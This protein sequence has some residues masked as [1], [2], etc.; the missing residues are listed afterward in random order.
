MRENSPGSLVKGTILERTDK[1]IKM[2]VHTI[3]G[4]APEDDGSSVITWFPLSQIDKIM[5]TKIIGE[6]SFVAS[7]WILEKKGFL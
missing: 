3:A 4:I 6:D 5:N 7:Q 1:A 2:D